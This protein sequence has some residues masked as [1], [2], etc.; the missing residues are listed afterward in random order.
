MECFSIDDIVKEKYDERDG[1]KISIEDKMY[2][3]YKSFS[4][5]SDGEYYTIPTIEKIEKLIKSI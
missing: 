5:G 2:D 3:N 1:A 4:K